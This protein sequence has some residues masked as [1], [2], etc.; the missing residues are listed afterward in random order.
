MKKVIILLVSIIVIAITFVIVT[1]YFASEAKSKNSRLEKQLEEL[2]FQIKQK[3]E[4]FSELE[5]SVNQLNERVASFLLAENKRVANEF[6]AEEVP[7]SF[8]MYENDELG[9]RF[10]YP[11]EW[12]KLDI[13]VVENASPTSTAGNGN[14]SNARVNVGFVTKDS[15]S[16]RL[17]TGQGLALYHPVRDASA[18]DELHQL[19]GGSN[20]Y[21]W[22]A[23]EDGWDPDTYYMAMS[24]QL[25]EYVYIGIAGPV[26]TSHETTQGNIENF[27]LA[28]RS[29]ELIQH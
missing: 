5:G 19:S 11:K 17:S 23:Y 25:A 22:Y 14:F 1:F 20:L 4:E 13:H 8:V 27:L 2:Q 15:N 7:S 16:N 9:F 29:F 28:M 26:M 12:G 18:A 3:E 10:W 6:G 24:A 21:M